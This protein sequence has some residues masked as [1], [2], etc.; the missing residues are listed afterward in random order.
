MTGMRTYRICFIAIFASTTPRLN[1]RQFVIFRQRVKFVSKLIMQAPSP[2]TSL[3]NII[4]FKEN[5]QLKHLIKTKEKLAANYRFAL[6][7]PQTNQT[8]TLNK[9]E[10]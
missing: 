4:L 5:Q 3:I 2:L 7:V 9:N 8:R 1:V 6:I 10:Q